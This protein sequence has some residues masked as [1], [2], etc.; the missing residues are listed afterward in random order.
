MKHSFMEVKVCLNRLK[1]AESVWWR[2]D[3][4]DTF[5]KSWFSERKQSRVLID[6]LAKL[7]PVN[8][9]T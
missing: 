1:K 3:G 5:K 2:A 9:A 7:F 4:C 6:I 8:I